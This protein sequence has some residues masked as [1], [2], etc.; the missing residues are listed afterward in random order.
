MKYFRF[1][2]VGTLRALNAP[3]YVHTSV[4]LVSAVVALSAVK[5]PVMALVALLS[6]L[7]IIFIHEIGHALVARKLGL[8]VDRIDIS[9]IHGSCH[10]EAPYF[11]WHDVLVSWGGVLAQLAVATPILVIG[12][13]G[14]LDSWSYFGPVWVFLGYVNLVI[15]AF[16]A[17][18]GPGLDGSMMWRIVPIWFGLRR[19][20]RKSKK[21]PRKS[22]LTIVPKDD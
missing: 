8:V 4:F 14:V 5:A 9:W 12:A 19:G 20:G 21:K 22:S 13:T 16:S 17:L 3:V 15:A 6:Y 1:F 2:R 7:G 11:E 18:P 10:Y